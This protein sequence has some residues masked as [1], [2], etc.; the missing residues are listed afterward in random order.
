MSIKNGKLKSID[1][2]NKFNADYYGSS[3]NIKNHSKNYFYIFNKKEVENNGKYC[4]DGI[5]YYIIQHGEK[6]A[7]KS[8]NIG[9]ANIDVDFNNSIKSMYGNPNHETYRLDDIYHI[10]NMANSSKHKC[11]ILIF[12]EVSIPIE[13][14][15]ILIDYSRKNGI[16]VIFGIEYF[17]T[18]NNKKKNGGKN[19]Y[20]YTCIALPF[21]DNGYKHVFVKFNLK[22]HGAP[23]ELEEINKSKYRAEES[24]ELICRSNKHN[25]YKN[26]PHEIDVFVWKGTYFSV[27]NCYELADISYRSKLVGKNDYTIA[28]EYNKD[29]P[30]FSSIIE[31]ISRDVHTYMV[32][33]NN[34]KY[35]DSRITRPA[36][37]EIKDIVK[38]KGGNNAT[39]MI[40]KIDI[41]S[42]RDFQLK[43]YSLQKMEKDKFK[44]TPPNYYVKMHHG[45]K[46]IH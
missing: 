7:P 11:D 33:V 38:I 37:T 25:K 27:F 46:R 9:I 19:V 14:I 26:D 45:R 23:N 4:D 12:P 24:Y 6:D 10:L 16:A 44:P 17:S 28:I 20:N 5:R 32:Q 35:G 41:E 1:I 31:S 29:I 21:K 18:N 2:T 22:L 36:K 43:E 3:D 40:G 34:S 39:L 15:E 8:L 13:W 30:Y 42:L